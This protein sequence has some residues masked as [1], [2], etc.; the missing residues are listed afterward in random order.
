VDLSKVE[1]TH[2]ALRKQG[3]RDL[4]L[5][6][7]G[8][9]LA[10]MTEP[11]GGD[12]HEKDKARLGEIIAA[13]N[14]LLEGDLTEDD[15]L[16]YVNDV[17]KTK[18]LESQI[19]IQQARNNTKEQFASSPD[20]EQELLNAIMDALAAHS[21]MSK[22]ALESDAVRLGIKEILLA[23]IAHSMR[24]PSIL[25]VVFAVEMQEQV[26]WHAMRDPKQVN[27]RMSRL[28]RA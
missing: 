10:P 28:S 7:D 26:V 6:G 5:T 16:V 27:R 13:V 23:C 20:L 15:K 22:Q 24:Q 19:L 21:A 9:A 12:V 18:L 17:L 14:D 3:Q 25:L 8:E 2:H 1:L 11:G 4:A